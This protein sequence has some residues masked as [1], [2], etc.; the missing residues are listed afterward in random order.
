MKHLFAEVSLGKLKIPNRLIR[1]AT[2]EMDA[3]KNG[4]ID[5]PVMQGIYG[6]L[7]EGG[8]GLIITGMMGVGYNSCVGGNMAKIYG[9]DFHRTFQAVV[10]AVQQF[11]CKI[12]AQLGQCGAKA[13]AIDLGDHPLAPSDIEAMR[14]MPAKAMTESDVKRVV[15]EFAEAAAK[16]REAG[17]DGIQLHAAHGYLLSQFLSPYYNKRQDEYG[18]SL[19][20]RARI[21]LEICDAVRLKVG[22]DYP[23]FVKINFS[24]LTDP[25]LD[26]HECTLICKELEK[27][28]IDAIEV[29]SGLAVSAKSAPVKAGIGLEGQGFFADGAMEIAEAVNIPV[30]SVGG[31]R[32]PDFAESTL[33]KSKIA[34]ISLCR[35]L[36]REP[37]LVKRWKAGDFSPSQ[38]V[39]C[40]GCFAET[41]KC[42]KVS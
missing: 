31:Y 29:S 6:K 42:R 7:A 4:V 34:A 32:S 2:M 41:L 14:K 22:K 11:G 23:L 39:S 33:N 21:L 16:C 3:V 18:G 15:S 8:V 20:N 24:D 35:P 9:E 1:S 25:G 28:G 10:A 19:E 30:I 5:V 40:N 12:V 37:G 38:C 13:R 17:A 27:R 36:V 26:G